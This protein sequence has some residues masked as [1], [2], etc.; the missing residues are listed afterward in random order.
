MLGRGQAVVTLRPGLVGRRA[1]LLQQILEV[2]G[3]GLVVFLLEEGQ[4]AQVIPFSVMLGASAY[5]F[6]YRIW[7]ILMQVGCSEACAARIHDYLSVIA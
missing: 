3:P 2:P 4:L 7:E 6:R 5:E 1:H